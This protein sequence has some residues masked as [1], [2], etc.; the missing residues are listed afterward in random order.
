MPTSATSTTNATGGYIYRRAVR[1]DAAAII[2]LFSQA[3]GDEDPEDVRE[4]IAFTAEHGH[5]WL[6]YRDSFVVAVDSAGVVVGAAQ[7]MPHTGSRDS[8]LDGQTATLVGIAVDKKHRHRGIGPIL[9][10]QSIQNMQALGFSR[11]YLEC[12]PGAVADWY[13]TLGWTL[14]KPGY[15]TAWIEPAIP[16]DNGTA[17]PLYQTFRPAYRQHAYLQIGAMLPLMRTEFVA[18]P[19]RVEI[20]ARAINAICTQL[21]HSPSALLPIPAATI[22]GL[23]ANPEAPDVFRSFARATLQAKQS[24]NLFRRDK[25]LLPA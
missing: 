3:F 7:C 24:L 19:D 21:S 4:R 23:M 9:L 25:I 13:H 6:M 22:A 20:Y 10:A 2:E 14:L 16:A 1:S 8:R 18:S 11:L 15:S 5:H 12:K 17:P